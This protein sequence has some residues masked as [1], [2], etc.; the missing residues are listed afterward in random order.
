MNEREKFEAARRAIA[1]K[2]A[3]STHFDI[4]YEI[5]Q[6]ALE[7]RVLAMTCDDI[8]VKA[9]EYGFKYWRASDAHGITGT[10]KQAEDLIAQLVG[11]EVEIKND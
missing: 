3:H 6:A 2:L 8:Q 10:V 5:W 1:A 11:V 7:S 9:L 4:E